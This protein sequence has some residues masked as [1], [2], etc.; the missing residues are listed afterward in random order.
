MAKRRNV[1]AVRIVAATAA[2]AAVCVLLGAAGQAQSG[3]MPR[4]A[5]GRPDLSGIWQAVSS[6]NWNIEPHAA[7]AGRLAETGAIGSAPGG[8]GIVEGGTIPYRPE[9]IAKRQDNFENRRTEDPEAKCYLPGVPR[10]TYMPFPFQIVQ[11]TNKIFIAYEFASANRVIHM[12]PVPESPVDTWMGHSVGRWDGD[13]LVVDVTAFNG[14][15]WFD[16]AG[17]HH[18][19]ALHV[20][21]RYTPVTPYHINYEAT[22]EDPNTFT[23]PWT[24]SLPL[25]RRMEEDVQ[26]L[27]FR[28]VEF[29]EEL[30]YGHLRKQE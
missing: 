20:V 1:K 29:S 14:Q 23:R 3:D 13:S 28:C 26:L 24:I 4:A 19:I 17:N 10:A 18:S 21:E 5:D 15:T 6:A 30:L 22:I 25:Y 11:G 9:A 2:V 12:D 7:Y 27:E 8:L 16:R